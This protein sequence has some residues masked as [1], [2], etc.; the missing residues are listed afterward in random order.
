[1]KDVFTNSSQRLLYGKS[2]VGL[3]EVHPM[4]NSHPEAI[5]F[6]GRCSERILF[7]EESNWGGPP[8]TEIP[9]STK[10]GIDQARTLIAGERYAEADKTLLYI[11]LGSGEKVSL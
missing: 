11:S 8:V 10:E 9:T 6:G 4:R 3:H 7:S 1:M 2:D 5:V